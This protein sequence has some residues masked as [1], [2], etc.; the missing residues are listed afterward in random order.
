MEIDEGRDL[1]VTQEHV[2][3]VAVAICQL[4]W[5]V[6]RRLPH[7]RRESVQLAGKGGIG[8]TQ[9]RI[10]RSFAGSAAAQKQPHYGSWPAGDSRDVRCSRWCR[11]LRE[12]V[13]QS[14]ADDRQLSRCRPDKDDSEIDDDGP[15]NHEEYRWATSL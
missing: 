14:A 7:G 1:P 11:S 3:I 2:A 13:E 4:S 8:P 9:P 12:C 5:E 15:E 6:G 10:D